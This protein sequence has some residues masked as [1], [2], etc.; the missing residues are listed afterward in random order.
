MNS[1]PSLWKSDAL[2]IELCLHF[3]HKERLE[4]SHLAAVASKTTVYTIPP[5]GQYFTYR[6]TLEVRGTEGTIPAMVYDQA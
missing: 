5:P 6:N 2:P 1:Q 3:V 4:L